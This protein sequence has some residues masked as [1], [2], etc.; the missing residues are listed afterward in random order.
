MTISSQS[1]FRG[2][3]AVLAAGDAVDTTVEFKARGSFEP[4]T[5]MLGGGVFGLEPG[6]WTDDTSMALCLAESL[7]ECQAFNAEDQ[8]D[9]YV[10]WSNEG[11][12]SSTGRCF[13]I[14]NTVSRALRNYSTYGNPNAGDDSEFSAGNGSIMRLAPIP[15]FYCY[16]DAELSQAAAASSITTHAARECVEACVLLSQ[17]IVRALRG[18]PREAVFSHAEAPESFAPSIEAINA[19]SYKH[20]TESEVTGSGYVVPSLEAALWAVWTTNNYRDAVLAAANLG[21]D[22]DTTAAIAGQ[23]AGALYG[24]ES[25][26]ENWREQLTMHEQIVAYADRLFELAQ[27]SS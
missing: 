22:A 13:D 19:G 7:I 21:D 10:R 14:G 1:R 5:D 3:L 2:C 4:V 12:L 15:M 24:Y 9:R 27:T 16:R 18:D 25:I 17:M 20:K 6:Q 11:Y 26:P 8:M 23:L